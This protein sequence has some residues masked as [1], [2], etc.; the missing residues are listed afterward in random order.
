MFIRNQKNR[1]NTP[2]LRASGLGVGLSG[3]M[4]SHHLFQEEMSLHDR[5]HNRLKSIQDPGVSTLGVSRRVR[6]DPFMPHTT[7]KSRYVNKSGY[8][9]HSTGIPFSIIPSQSLT[10]ILRSSEVL[11]RLTL[12]PPGARST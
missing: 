2:S 12:A 3:E 10:E 8:G 9:S 5:I 4:A 11:E 6:H 7:T 1:L